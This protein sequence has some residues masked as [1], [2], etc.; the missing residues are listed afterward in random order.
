[1]H[2][3]DR[4][5]TRLLLAH[6]TAQPDAL[7][8]T[9]AAA[10][11]GIG[12]RD[13]ALF[14]IDYGHVALAPHLAV[15]RPGSDPEVV[16]LDGSMA[17]RAF[18]SSKV[19]A[20]EHEDGWHVWVPVSEQS[21]RLGVLFMTLPRWDDEVE[22]L[23]TELGLAAAP[24]L[25]ATAQYTDLPHLMRRRGDMDL[26][27]E[28]QWS[29]LPPLSFAAA[30]MTNAGLLEPAYNVGGDCFDYAFNAGILDLTILDTVGHGINSAILAALLVGAY[31]HSRRVG[32][33]LATMATQMDAAAGMFPAQ[34]A[35]ATAILGRLDTSLG[36]FDWMSCGHPLP[37][38]IR[39]GEIVS[40]PSVRPGQPLGIGS[41]GAVVGDITRVKPSAR[42]RRTAVH[43][44]RDRVPHAGR[45]VLR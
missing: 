37:I 34:P 45:H 6:Q 2:S 44:W 17:G 24:L 20:A 21:N 3:R 41:L 23:V 26:A 36:M 42:R 29:L 33:D 12:G 9:L 40:E 25:L 14:L 18:T 35:L 32:A 13:V 39:D 19:L 1:M 15:P 5:V 10:V 7:V 22:F 8:E 4:P 28:M 30:G 38:V 27:A 16:S 11:A 43:R 31:R